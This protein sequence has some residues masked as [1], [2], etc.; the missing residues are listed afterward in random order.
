MI[1]KRKKRRVSKTID[2][3][4]L[5]VVGDIIWQVW[6]ILIVLEKIYGLLS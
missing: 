5:P 4:Q 6:I 2:I 1:Y 3:Q